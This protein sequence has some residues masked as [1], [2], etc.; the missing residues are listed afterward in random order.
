[1]VL[2]YLHISYSI[3]NISPQHKASVKYLAHDMFLLSTMYMFLLSTMYMFRSAVIFLIQKCQKSQQFNINKVMLYKCNN[4]NRFKFP[5]T[6]KKKYYAYVT[7][8][9]AQQKCFGVCSV[10]HN[11]ELSIYVLF[12]I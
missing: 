10:S 7:A 1:M 8:W 6:F 4:S 2:F 9:K 3:A 5:I 12:V 11:V